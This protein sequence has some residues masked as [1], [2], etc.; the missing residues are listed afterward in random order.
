MIALSERQQIV[1]WIE[2]AHAAGARQAKACALLGISL[3]SLQRWQQ[4]GGIAE[5]GRRRRQFI[6]ANKLSDQE[7]Q[8]VLSMANSA[9][10]AALAPSQIVPIL[11]ER[12][13]YLASESTFYRILR[14]AKQLKHRQASRVAAGSRKP[15]ALKATAPNQLYSWDITYLPTSVKGVFLYLYLFMDVYSRK[16]VGWQVYERESSDWAADIV[17]DIVQREGIPRHQVALHSDNGGPMKGAT[18]LATLQTLGIL[19]SFSRPAVSND[20]PYSE[21]LFKTLKYRPEYPAQP[22]TDL[23]Q[24]RRWVAGFVD[25]YNQEHRHSAIRFVTPHQRHTGQDIAILKR[26]KAVYEAAKQQR[27]ERWRGKTRNWDPI[28]AVYL[29][30]D[31]EDKNLDRQAVKKAA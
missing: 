28:R 23:K 3:R 25:W 24:A 4:S 17:R 30:P 26:R 5:D 18:M 1:S 6:P 27:P 8:A 20:N 13:Q 31:K 16:I 21:A 19:P 29:N 15:K 7:R 10:F 11:A 9:E 22:F 12:G 2:E 14:D